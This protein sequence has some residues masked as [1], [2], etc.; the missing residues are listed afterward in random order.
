MKWQIKKFDQL[1]KKQL[2]SLM[3][4]RADVFVVEQDCP[5]QDLDGQDQNAYHLLGHLKKDL[6]AYARIFPPDALQPEYSR[7]GRIV[8]SQ[9]YRGKGIG[10]K[11]VKKSIDF[12]RKEFYKYP[13]KI[14]AQERLKGFYTALGFSAGGKGYIEDGIP[15]CA[16]YLFFD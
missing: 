9:D 4:L 6:V 14:S 5:Y 1:K 10:K 7:I 11:L 13:I 16:M 15:H 2:Y 8:T 12:C 3:R